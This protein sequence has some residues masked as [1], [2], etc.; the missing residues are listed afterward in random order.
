MS[1][2]Q[3]GAERRGVAARGREHACGGELVPEGIEARSPRG[4]LVRRPLRQR[5]L[6]SAALSLA[7][8]LLVLLAARVARAVD[9]WTSLAVLGT[10]AVVGYLAAD[11]VSGLVHWFG[12][13]VFAEATPLI[14]PLF[15]A[16][17]REHHRDPLA[18]TRHDALELLGNSALG[19]LPM[20]GVAWCWAESLFTTG[21]A[22]ALGLAGIAANR[23]HAW[24]HAS[25]VP[26]PIAWLQARGL[27]LPPAHHARHHR[28]RHE[29]AFCVTSGW[30]NR[31][32][33][34]LRLFTGLER[35]LRALRFPVAPTG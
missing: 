17:F 28:G 1:R 30:M 8:V 12:D 21:L 16:P 15:I 11:L 5:L 27:I 19:A 10:A 31:W 14:G 23:F 24:A 22:I 34:G 32:T 26:P 25:R 35:A 9:G 3:H 29:A 20:L 33:D 7:I 13:R 6:E 18:M 2:A 4:P